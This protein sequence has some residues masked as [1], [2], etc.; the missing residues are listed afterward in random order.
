M[1]TPQKTSPIAPLFRMLNAVVLPLAKAGLGSPLPVGAGVVV[2]ETTGRRSNLP[3]QVPL[4]ATRLGDR[5]TVSTVRKDSQW[6]G[7]LEADRNA[8]VWLNGKRRDVVATSIG[9]GPLTTVELR[10][11]G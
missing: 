3:R 2:L 8:A 1:P 11:A 6:V 7:N 10:T 5:I 4:A 9:R